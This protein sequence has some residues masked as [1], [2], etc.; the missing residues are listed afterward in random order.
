MSPV[1]HARCFY[2]SCDCSSDLFIF[3]KQN[4]KKKVIKKKKRSF[5]AIQYAS[6]PFGCD[7]EVDQKNMT[8][9]KH[10]HLCT[11]GSGVFATM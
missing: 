6:P 3:Q 5:F 11:S 10:T 9:I 8:K 4:N 2:F 1:F 7:A